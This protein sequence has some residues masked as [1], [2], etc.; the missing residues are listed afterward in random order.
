MRNSIDQYEVLFWASKCRS[1]SEATQLLGCSHTTMLRAIDR[2]EER[3][4]FKVLTRSNQGIDLTP[5]GERI[6]DVYRG[7]RLAMQKAETPN[8]A[9]TLQ[10]RKVAIA[11]TDFELA[12]VL[13]TFIIHH[14]DAN[15][16]TLTICSLK[17]AINL[18]STGACDIAFAKDASEPVLDKLIESPLISKTISSSNFASD[19]YAIYD[20]RLALISEINALIQVIK[21]APAGNN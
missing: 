8:D 5:A 15:G 2:L 11:V 13:N 18:V 19:V 9:C 12:A 7:V 10:C 3:L 16:T 14:P 4:G 6:I 21:R 1:F 20:R 17:T